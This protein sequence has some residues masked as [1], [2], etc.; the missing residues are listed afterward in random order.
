MAMNKVIIRL[1]Y[2]ERF[3]TE[4]SDEDFNEIIN[5]LEDESVLFIRTHGL[6]V[7]RDQI[8]YVKKET[9]LSE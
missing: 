9:T 7:R 5:S 2:G 8:V 3:E 6:A 1:S 4:M